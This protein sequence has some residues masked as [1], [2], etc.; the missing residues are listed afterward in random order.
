MP[1]SRKLAK[2]IVSGK[3]SLEDVISLLTTYKMLALLPSLKKAITQMTSV[4]GKRD[5]LMIESPF[6]LSD[7]SITIIKN[8][9]GDETVKYEVSINKSILSGFKARFKGHLYD[10]SAERIIK[11]LINH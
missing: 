3:A 8:I 9:V 11:Q 5:T 2:L 7:E 4:T 10:A 6:P 1:L